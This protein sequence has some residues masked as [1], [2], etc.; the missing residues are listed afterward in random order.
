MLWD[1]PPSS[2]AS[3]PLCN[4]SN[5]VPACAIGLGIFHKRM[6]QPRPLDNVINVVITGPLRQ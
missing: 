3:G 2:K 4:I 5:D 6:W 1:P